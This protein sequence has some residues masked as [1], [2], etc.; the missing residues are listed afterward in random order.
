MKLDMRTI[1]QV[2]KAYSTQTMGV[3][4]NFVQDLKLGHYIKVAPRASFMGEHSSP[5]LATV[6]VARDLVNN[7]DC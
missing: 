2:F 1:K 6:A 3:A 7:S 4:I 5:S